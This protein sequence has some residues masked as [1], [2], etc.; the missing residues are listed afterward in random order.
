LSRRSP[1]KRKLHTHE[2]IIRKPRTMAAL[3]RWY[4]YS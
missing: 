3:L 4:P 2:Q 1:M